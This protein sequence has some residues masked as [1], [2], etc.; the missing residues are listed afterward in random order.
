MAKS[1]LAVFIA[2]TLCAPA[3]AQDRPLVEG[4]GVGGTETLPQLSFPDAPLPFDQWEGEEFVFLPTPKMY[5]EDGYPDCR[6]QGEPKTQHMT[7]QEAVGRIA[8]VLEV[9]QPDKYRKVLRLK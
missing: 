2:L 8:T 7:Y 9:T 1:V 6:K 4:L 5:E 3:T